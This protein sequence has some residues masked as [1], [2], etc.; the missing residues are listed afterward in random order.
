MKILTP[1]IGII[2][3]IYIFRKTSADTLL[4]GIGQGK[5]DYQI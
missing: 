3:T 1:F 2:L 5:K 4:K